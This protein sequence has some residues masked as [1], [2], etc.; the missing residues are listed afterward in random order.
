MWRGRSRYH[1]I[2]LLPFSFPRN[3]R[4]STPRHSVGSATKFSLRVLLF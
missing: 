3:L 2:S 1:I 4:L